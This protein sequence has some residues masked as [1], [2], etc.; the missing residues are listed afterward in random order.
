MSVPALS[1]A[2]GVAVYITGTQGIKTLLTS[3]KK[4]NLSTSALE[5][6]KLSATNQSGT[7]SHVIPV[8]WE[9]EAGGWQV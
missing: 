3:E 5:G 1:P 2:G 6:N 8:L 7:V 9:T 4:K